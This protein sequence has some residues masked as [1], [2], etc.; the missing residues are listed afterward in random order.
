M[1]GIENLYA[2]I[3]SAVF[4]AS[5]PVIIYLLGRSEKGFGD[6]SAGITYMDF[7]S[8]IM[9]LVP[10]MAGSAYLFMAFG[11]GYV[12]NAGEIVYWIRYYEW[13]VITP[14]IILGVLVLTQDSKLMLKGMFANFL[15]IMVG[16]LG[17][18]APT[19]ELRAL[20]FGASTFLFI[21]LFYLVVVKA[22][23][24]MEDSVES[25]QSLFHRLKLITVVVWIVYPLV[26]AL[27]PDLANVLQ[28]RN[29]SITFMALDLVSKIGY[30]SLIL[31]GV[32]DVDSGSTGKWS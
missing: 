25:L 15:M 21:Y 18:I 31:L 3:G 27:G 23:R 8:A 13:A 30:V 2:L 5:V 26:W 11:F 12:K 1:Y 22:S 20:G 28:G 6:F 17:E 16:F 19:P 32:S 14:L 10:M 7:Y 9:L 29:L 4:L 24:L